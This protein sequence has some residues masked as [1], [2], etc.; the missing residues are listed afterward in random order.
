MHLNSWNLEAD[1]ADV[2]AIDRKHIL[3]ILVSGVTLLMAMPLFIVIGLAILLDCGF[4]IF[5]AQERLGQ[6]GKPFTMYKFRTMAQ[7][8]EGS[9]GPIWAR[10][11]DPRVTRVGIWLRRT[12]LDE[13]PQLINVLRGDMSM[14]GPR[15]ERPCLSEEICQSFPQFALRLLVKPG[16]TGLAQ[17]NG[18]YDL[19]PLEKLSWDMHYIN[20]MSIRYDL[21]ILL[22]TPWVMISGHGAR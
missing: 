15:P 6:F 20:Y 12:R 21:S 3:D 4:P 17:V 14:V 18:G 2:K 1:V 5:Y 10:C 9:T 13:L 22:R 11:N 16:I 8:A 19:S 7:N